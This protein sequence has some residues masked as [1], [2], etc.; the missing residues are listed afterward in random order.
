MTLHT[1]LK[2]CLFAVVLAIS[3]RSSANQEHRLF[4]AYDASNGLADN[5]AQIVMCAPNGR[6]V[7]STLGHINFYDGSSF[8]HVDPQMS[9]SYSLPQYGG[10][11]QMYF[12]RFSHLW[13][14]NNRL[15]TCVDLKTERF[16]G[17]V[18]KELKS[19]GV[20]RRVDDLYG[21]GWANIWFRSGNELYSQSL[22]K[23]FTLVQYRDILDV[24]I[25][26]DSLLLAF[27]A[28]GS[29][30]VFDYQHG[31]RMY[32]VH[33]FGKSERHR[34]SKS[35][36]LCMVDNVYYQLHHGTKESV[37]MSYNPESAQWQK[38]YE[39][40][41]LMNSLYPRDNL[42]YIGAEEGYLIY[43][44]MTGQMTHIETLTLTKGRHLRAHVTS[45]AFDRQGG[46]WLG[47]QRRGILY[48][49]PFSSP[50]LV[51]D[52]EHPK[53]HEYLSQM[54]KVL[55]KPSSVV[56]PPRVNCIFRDSRGWTWTG[57][58]TGLELK[59]SEGRK[60]YTFMR[61]DGLPND[62]IHSVIEDTQHN[63]W[64]STSFGIARLVIKEK[65][66]N[67]ISYINQDNV[68]SETFL[69]GRAVCLSDGAVVMQ[70][71][72][73]VLVFNPS[74]F[75][76]QQIEKMSLVPV[77]SQLFVNGTPIEAGSEING[78]VIIDT[79]VSQIKHIKVNYNQ[80][81]LSLVFSG[82]NFFRP[83]QTNYRIRVK[84]LFDDWRI[85]SFCNSGGMVDKNGML[86]VSLLG[87][88]PGKYDI[89]LQASQTPDHWLETPVVW[90]VYV[91]QPW[92]R[93]TGLYSFLVVVLLLLIL[94][95]IYMFNRNTSLRMMCH[96]EEKNIIRRIRSLVN[97]L[98]SYS[99]EIVKSFTN[100]QDAVLGSVDNSSKDY[101]DAMVLIVPYIR[102]LNGKSF[103]INELAAQA[104][105]DVAELYNL[106]AT[107]IDKSPRHLMTRLR[108]EEG[109]E[110]LR[111]TDLSEDAIA[112]KCHFVSPNFFISTFYHFY[113]QTPMD[114]R[115]SK[116][117]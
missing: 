17:N 29:V 23:H 38:L 28:D 79:A 47:T 89:E 65:G 78:E 43:D 63:I 16:I 34:F 12:D 45:L 2:F 1:H 48:S 74:N 116:A 5:S 83:I 104:D 4:Y 82:L 30:T 99:G 50:F 115:K 35:S 20:K 69:N 25:Y 103:T 60:G 106:L 102:G 58:Q 87:L 113:R 39:A 3:A 27:H 70:S 51:Y 61:K 49:R 109:A 98:D 56:L 85:L 72:D 91:E 53:A 66:W 71:L 59:K 40:P 37:L 31:N 73:H 57:T 62:V 21:D 101:E 81:S 75:H 55:T 77:L 86:H 117:L 110:L 36:E 18:D 84:G 44:L 11:Y 42:I 32:Q 96:S 26:K 64:V 9:N 7:T 76:D 10:K 33:A 52:M 15:M 67:V 22:K 80:N 54:D 107:H 93:T 92:W 114:Y 68:P 105:I 24:D 41:F 19:M 95:N 112:E 111:Q 88:K 108:I 97:R 13:I 8:K 90:T 100:S 94:L 46:M 6:I 14:K